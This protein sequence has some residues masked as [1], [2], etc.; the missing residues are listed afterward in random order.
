MNYCC[1][2]KKFFSELCEECVKCMTTF[3]PYAVNYAEYHDE[4]WPGSMTTT[5]CECGSE[6]VNGPGHSQWC[7]KYESK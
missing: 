1:Q 3:D 7:P 2:D 6:A 4:E 5:K